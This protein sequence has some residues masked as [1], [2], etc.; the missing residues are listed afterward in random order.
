MLDKIADCVSNGAFVRGAP[1]KRWREFDLSKLE[2]RVEIDGAVIVRQVGG[3]PTKD[4]LLPAVD[5]VNDLRRS[6]GVRAGQFMTTGTF[7]GL[8]FA[9]PGQRS[10]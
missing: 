1:Q 5:L 2:A 3:H 8:N 10:R 6:L 7:T 9:K 4:P